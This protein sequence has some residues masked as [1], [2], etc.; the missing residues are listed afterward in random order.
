MPIKPELRHFYGK[1]WRTET[2]PRILLRAGNC[3]EVCR[4]P[5]HALVIRAMGWWCHPRPGSGMINYP[6]MD[7]TVE[8]YWNQPDGRGHGLKGFPPQICRFVPIVLTVAHLNH[9]A[10]DDRDENL[11]AMCQWCHLDYDKQHHHESRADRKDRGRPLLAT[12]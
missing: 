7:R 5:N 2:R 8:L 6:H 1:V 10:G 11:K 3:C 4:V 12:S 9:V